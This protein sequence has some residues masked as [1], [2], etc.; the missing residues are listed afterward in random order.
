MNAH[1]CSAQHS[2]FRRLCT[3]EGCEV[4]N[5]I[6]FDELDQRWEHVVLR[7]P[8]L[9]LVQPHREQV[10]VTSVARSKG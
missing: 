6:G 9:H 10:Y 2:T 4:L 3:R 8:A 7:T 1:R 5:L